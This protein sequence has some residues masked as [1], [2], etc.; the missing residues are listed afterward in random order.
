MTTGQSTPRRTK[1]ASSSPAG[2]R[3]ST[4]A[5]AGAAA[6]AAA[7]D[8]AEASTAR[9]SRRGSDTPLTPAEALT[10]LTVALDECKRAGIMIGVVGM[11]RLG[12]IQILLKLAEEHRAAVDWSAWPE[13]KATTRRRK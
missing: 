11:R 12:S 7:P 5:G 9:Q 4:G 6:K 13:P 2:A 1:A 8:T 10:L 3:K